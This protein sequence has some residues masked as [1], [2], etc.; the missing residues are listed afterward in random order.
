VIRT[1]DYPRHESGTIK[2][3]SPHMKFENLTG[4]PDWEDQRPGTQEKEEEELWKSDLKHQKAV[5]LYN[6]WKSILVLLLGLYDG[7]RQSDDLPGKD[8][9]EN[10]KAMTLEEAYL[11]GAKIRGAEAGNHYVLRMENAS[12]IRKA[13]Q[14]VYIHVSSLG[15]L[16]VTEDH[17]IDAIKKELD[18][19]RGYFKEWVASFQKDDFEDEWGLYT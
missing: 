2:E 13:A 17:D 19:F 14:A 8:Y 7:L 16:G 5:Q 3:K 12:M 9:L 15:M 1:F 10:E 6:Q 11:V 4:M 18:K